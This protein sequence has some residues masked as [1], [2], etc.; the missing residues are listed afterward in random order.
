MRILIIS[1][2]VLAI[3]M[4]LTGCGGEAANSAGLNK[5]VVPLESVVPDTA[6]E[7]TA[8]EEQK[9]RICDYDFSKYK[10]ALAKEE[11]DGL[12]LALNDEYLAY[13]TYEKVNKD[14]NDPR[15]FVNIQK[16]EGRHIERLKAVFA[17]YDLPV[18]ENSWMGNAP[19]FK[20]LAEA[21]EAGIAGEIANRDL[22]TKLF[23]STKRED[24]ITVYKALQSASEENHLPAFQRCVS[25]GGMGRGRGGGPPSRQ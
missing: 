22:Y 4:A 15:P 21:C 9:C 24:I 12:L 23:N 5:N 16:A 8:P 18:P 3:P 17:S 14:F 7:P 6:T 19:A 10:G 20:S 1:L 11:V 25:G 2:V 13:A